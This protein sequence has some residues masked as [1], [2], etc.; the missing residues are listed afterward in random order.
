MALACGGERTSWERSPR[1]RRRSVLRV[2]DTLVVTR[3]AAPGSAGPPPRIPCTLPAVFADVRAGERI[4]LRRRAHRR[5]HRQRS[6][7]DALAVEIT[8]ADPDG[9]QA[10][11][12]QRHQPARHA[13]RSCRALDRQRRAPI[14]RSSP[15]TPMLVGYSFVRRAQRRGRAARAARARSAA[16][17][18]GIVLKIE[19]REA[20]EAL[21]QPAAGGDAPP[22]RRRDD[23]A[24]RS[25]GRV[26]LGAAGGGAGGDPLD[27]RGRARA[28]HLGD[29]GARELAK[30]GPPVA[31]R[32][33]RRGDGGARRVR[34]AQ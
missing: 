17:D 31:R 29:A 19:T 3:D 4:W 32:D 22:R 34:D 27:L 21:P 23:R 33:H 16:R 7:P 30:D 6:T 14:C 5:P 26:R 18:L 13:A 11:R 2:G 12:R 28:G 1:P 8:D 20:F 15:R 24:R 25:G 10:A 9:D